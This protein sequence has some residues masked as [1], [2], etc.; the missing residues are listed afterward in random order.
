MVAEC[1]LTV[2]IYIYSVNIDRVLA[3]LFMWP[4][5]SMLM[6]LSVNIVSALAYATDC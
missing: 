2:S 6:R 1:Q 3:D 4:K 5:V